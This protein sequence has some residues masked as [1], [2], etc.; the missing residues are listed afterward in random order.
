[1]IESRNQGKLLNVA[2][3]SIH[4]TA[5]KKNKLVLFYEV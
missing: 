1:M 3:E 5:G 4:S 2:G